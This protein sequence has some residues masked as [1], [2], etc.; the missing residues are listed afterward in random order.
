MANIVKFTSRDYESIK[1]DLTTYARQDI[2]NQEWTDFSESDIGVKIINMIAAVGDMLSFY[3][4]TQALEVFPETAKERKNIKAALSITGYKFDS[5]T[6]ARTSVV[7]NVQ[8][9][10]SPILIRKYSRFGTSSQISIGS[11][12]CTMEDTLIQPSETEEQLTLQ[13]IQGTPRVMELNLLNTTNNFIRLPDKEVDISVFSVIVD[14]FEWFRVNEGTDF[15][16]DQQNY[17]LTD[18]KYDNLFV[19]IPTPLLG[20]NVSMKITYLLSSGTQGRIGYNKLKYILDDVINEQTGLSVSNYV[21]VLSNEAST[22]G[23]NPETVEHAKIQAPLEVKT[24]WVAIT[25]QDFQTLTQ[26]LVGVIKAKAL[27]CNESLELVPSPY[28]VKLLVIPQGNGQASAELKAEILDYFQNRRLATLD[29]GFLDVDYVEFDIV[30]DVYFKRGT[31]DIAGRASLI[32]ASLIE[33][34]KLENLNFGESIRLSSLLSEIQF[35]DPFIDYVT[36]SSP[37]GD[38]ILSG[39]QFPTL[40]VVQIIPHEV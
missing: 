31:F 10:D 24:Q 16:Q 17:L 26:G 28:A 35:A 30:A 39:Y 38:I 11:T 37:D 1:Q 33:T 21:S 15:S 9:H 7:L 40:G 3:Q 20:T 5:I 27:D 6:S 4:D 22:S 2:N 29:L 19:M 32:S 13:V 23:E 34:F 12:F 18:D 8:P 14:G 25:L 36:L